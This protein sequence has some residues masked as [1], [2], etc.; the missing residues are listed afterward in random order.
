[1]GCVAH[2]IS[3]G[4]AP[5][6]EEITGVSAWQACQRLAGLPHLLFLDSAAS[7]DNLGRWSFVTAD[8]FAWLTARGQHV[9]E[10]GRSRAA[11]PFAVLT[12]QLAQYRSEPLPE[13]PPF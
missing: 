10:N 3:R 4:P 11:D 1:M 8:P 5:R 12:R 6:V 2:E 7:G 13:L 9:I